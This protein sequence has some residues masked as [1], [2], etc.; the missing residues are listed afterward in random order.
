MSKNTHCGKLKAN[1]KNVKEVTVLR[2]IF[3]IV[4]APTP[5]AT[6]FKICEAS[7]PRSSNYK[8]AAQI[9]SGSS[10]LELLQFKEMH[11]PPIGLDV[12]MQGGG[13]HRFDL[14]WMLRHPEKKS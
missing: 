13:N 6:N 2:M 12:C 7:Q 11:S 4:E 14:T 10:T 9:A 8:Q 3:S 5:Y 1:K